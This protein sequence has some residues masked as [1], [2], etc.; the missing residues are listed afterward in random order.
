MYCLFV[1]LMNCNHVKNGFIFV[2]AFYDAT[3]IVII[4]LISV[5]CYFE[6]YAW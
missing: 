6:V 5:G 4:V 3:I 1:L 2:V